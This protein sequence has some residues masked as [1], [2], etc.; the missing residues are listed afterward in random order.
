MT[1]I[2]SFLSRCMSVQFSHVVNKSYLYVQRS[3]RKG[4]WWL[5][6]CNARFAFWV[7]RGRVSER[8]RNISITFHHW[9]NIPELS[10][11]YRAFPS[12]ESVFIL[13]VW[14][15]GW[16]DAK[17]L[18]S[19][20]IFDY[21]IESTMFWRQS[22]TENIK[23][24]FWPKL[25]YGCGNGIHSGAGSWWV[26]GQGY[27][28]WTRCWHVIEHELWPRRISSLSYPCILSG[29]CAL[30]VYNYLISLLAESLCQL[31]FPRGVKQWRWRNCQRMQTSI[32]HWYNATSCTCLQT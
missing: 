29:R 2:V 14:G 6:I 15:I 25:Y 16:V 21:I 20:H 28:K 5:S 26:Y 13:G 8:K 3:A 24:K 9:S 22:M 31:F 10:L 27:N 18:P 12:C 4:F 7:W 19:R 1:K 32:H 23:I 11:T 30:F 17:S